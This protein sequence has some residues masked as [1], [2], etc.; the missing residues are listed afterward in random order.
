MFY[1]YTG[2][3]LP[4]I[5]PIG[6]PPNKCSNFLLLSLKSFIAEKRHVAMKKIFKEKKKKKRNK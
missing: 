6:Q 3:E 1:S 2:S 5:Y 4:K